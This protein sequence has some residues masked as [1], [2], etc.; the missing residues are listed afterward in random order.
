MDSN[1]KR[2]L[3]EQYKLYDD[4]ICVI[5]DIMDNIHLGP[6]PIIKLLKKEYSYNWDFKTGHLNKKKINYIDGWFDYK[7]TFYAHVITHSCFR[8]VIGQQTEYGLYR[9]PEDILL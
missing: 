3:T 2:I 5:S 6:H 1:T 4:V 8:T 9:D 7:R